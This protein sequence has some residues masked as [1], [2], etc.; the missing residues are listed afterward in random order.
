MNMKA[1]SPR[2]WGCFQLSKIKLLVQNLFP[3]PVGVFLLYISTDIR[4]CS[5]PHAR[6]GVSTTLWSLSAGP[7]SSPRRGG[8]SIGKSGNVCGLCSSPRPWGCF[9]SVRSI[10]FI[11]VSSPRT[12]GCF[13]DRDCMGQQLDLF[14]TPVG[15]FPLPGPCVSPVIALPHARGGVSRS[16]NSR[17]QPIRSSPCPWGCF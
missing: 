2:P 3:T 14:P 9:Y 13:Q 12:W 1:S 4:D 11:S 15:V 10:L 6:G 7:P 5:L 8:V 17:L 16:G